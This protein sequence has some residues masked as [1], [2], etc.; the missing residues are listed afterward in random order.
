MCDNVICRCCPGREPAC[1]AVY[2][3]AWQTGTLFKKINCFLHNFIRSSCNTLNIHI[4]GIRYTSCR[5]VI[6]YS[7]NWR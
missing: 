4:H 3:T 6:F 5:F 2:F 7:L 1:K